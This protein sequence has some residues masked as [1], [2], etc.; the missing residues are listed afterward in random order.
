[1]RIL[2]LVITKFLNIRLFKY[3]IQQTLKALYPNTS[4]VYIDGGLGSQIFK[5]AFG[6]SLEK[7][8]NCNVIYDV[9]WFSKNGR[10]IDNKNTR[11]FQLCKVFPNVKIKLAPFIISTLYKKYYYFDNNQMPFYYHKDVFITPPVY[12]GGFYSNCKFFNL[13]EEKLRKDLIFNDNIK[14]EELDFQELIKNAKN[15]VA[16]HI[17]RG[18]YV[19]SIHDVLNKEYYIK[20]I[21]LIQK[22]TSNF[23]LFFFSNDNDWVANNIIPLLNVNI[24]YYNYQG[25][26]DTGCIDMYL[27]SLCSKI[28][29]SNSS[30]SWIPAWLN[31]EMQ[32]KIIMPIIWLNP[33][34]SFNTKG[35]ETA[36][37]IENATY[38]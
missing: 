17:R 29:I 28:I 7:M 22:E 5:Y 10:S 3:I 2:N 26:N 16:V 36:F 34:D 15:A 38:I 31:N 32:K 19:N 8:T 21:Q 1:M 20:A 12:Y 27:M 23:T 37:N 6:L 25:N 30:F 33:Q 9:S 4:I 24:K 18:D 35:L 13:S 14:R 11:N